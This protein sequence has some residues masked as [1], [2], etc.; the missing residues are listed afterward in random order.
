M[1]RIL[2]SLLVALIL[3]ATLSADRP[4]RDPGLR[5]DRDHQRGRGRHDHA[6]RAR[7]DQRPADHAVPPAAA[8]DG[9]VGAPGPIT[10][11]STGPER[12]HSDALYTPA[13]NY[14]G[15][16][17]FNF[18]ATVPDGPD[19]ATITITITAVNDAPAC[20]GDTSTGDEDTDQAATVV[21]TDIDSGALT[22]SK[23]GGP[24]HGA[25][26]V[27]ANG[28]WTYTPAANY[29]GSDSFHVPRRRR[30]PVRGHRHD[31]ADDPGRER[32]PHLRQRRQHRRQEPA[33]DGHDRLRRRRRREPHD[34]QGVGPQPWLG[35][36]R[37][38]R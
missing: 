38:R 7:S 28:S 6:H 17:Q 24:A 27:N 29:N 36:R 9:T 11:D 21:C 19:T 23:V 14:N 13:A 10:C 20:V 8:A 1:R 15:A 3:S 2:S 4:G 31:V 30:H 26:T 12:C 22:Y 33:A 5:W 18:T 16:D 25:A 35:Q 34:R 37:D 32:R